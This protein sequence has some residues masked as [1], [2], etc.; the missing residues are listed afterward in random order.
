M[1]KGVVTWAML[2][3]LGQG[4]AGCGGSNSSHNPVS[5]SPP[6]PPVTTPTPPSTFLGEISIGELVPASGATLVMRDCGGS[7]N[8]CTD[9][10]RTTFD[11]VMPFDV[12]DAV[13]IV[14][15]R[16]AS[17]ACASGRSA[18]RCHRTRGFYSARRR[19]R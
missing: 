11:V 7:R 6:P 19:S 12:E 18:Q 2:M 8:L 1:N 9:Q 16:G 10:L 5:P 4:L 15:L 14:S 3:M 13:V 17:T